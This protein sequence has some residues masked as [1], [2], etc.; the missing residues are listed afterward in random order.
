MQTMYDLVWMQAERSPEALALVDDRTDRALS[1]R[2]MIEEIDAIAAGFSKRGIGGVS[3]VATC[4]PNVWEHG[5]VTLALRRL[6]AI[7]ALINPRLKRADIARLIQAGEFDGAVIMA[8]AELADALAPF[9]HPVRRCSRSAVRPA[10]RA[11]SRTAVA[12]AQLC[13]QSQHRNRTK[14]RLFF[15]PLAPPGCPKAR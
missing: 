4:M 9:C 13:R 11:I 1:Y 14:R 10:P 7:P 3:K 5:L 15:I 8:D 6:N 2:G 12:T